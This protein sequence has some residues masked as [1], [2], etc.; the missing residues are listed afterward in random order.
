MLL[1]WGVVITSGMH[2]LRIAKFSIGGELRRG[3]KVQVIG[4]DMAT[5]FDWEG[6]K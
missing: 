5:V 6:R 3:T 1:V 2:G 4:N